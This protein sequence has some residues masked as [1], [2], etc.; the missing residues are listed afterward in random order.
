MMGW[1]VPTSL[2]ACM[3]LTRIVWGVMVTALFYATPVLYPIDIVS[4]TLR[5]LVW[6][7]LHGGFVPE[8]VKD[9]DVAF[10]D[11]RASEAPPIDPEA[12]A[13]L[14]EDAEI[15]TVRRHIARRVAEE[16]IEQVY[17]GLTARVKRQ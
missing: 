7:G 5:D 17:P 1:S 6:D 16:T 13:S 9:V 8:R 12:A 14:A 10:Y 11:R 4:G 3:I 15:P 2:F